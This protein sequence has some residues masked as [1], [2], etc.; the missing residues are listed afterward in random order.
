MLPI[1]MGGWRKSRQRAAEL[2]EAVGLKDQMHKRADRISG[3]QA[4]RAAIV[5]GL[6]NKPSIV[7]A[8]EPTGNLDTVNSKSVVQLMKTMCKTMGQTFV[9]VTHDRQDF[10]DVDR[11]IHMRDGQAFQEMAPEVVR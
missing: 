2:L 5:R 4:Q 3:G 6:A 11:I 10:G 9:V 7:L 8:D 1:Q